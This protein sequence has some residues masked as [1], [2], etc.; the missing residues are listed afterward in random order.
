M[1][2]LVPFPVVLPLL[3]GTTLVAFSPISE[4]RITDA[5]S[6]ATALA[7]MVVC[8][9]L[10]HLSAGNTIVYWFGDWLPR[11]RVAMGISFVIDPMGA[12]LAAFCAFLMTVAFIY[13]IHYFEEVRTYFHALMLWF[14]AA[15]TGFCLTGDLFN[16]FVFFE[17]MSVTAFT[18][19]AYKVEE[20]QTPTGAFNFAVT[21]SIGGFLTLTGIALVYG[22]TGALNMAQAGVSLVNHPADA[23][24]MVAL[25]MIFSGFFIKAAIVPFHFWLGDAH[26]VA[27]APV[28]VLFSGVM[29]ELGLYGAFRVYWIV[30]HPSLLVIEPRIRVLLMTL[31]CST[32]VMGAIMCFLQRHLKRLLAFSS[33]SHV[34][35]MLMGAACLTAK[36]VAG[37]ALY[38]LAHGMVKGALFMGGGVLLARLGSVDEVMLARRGG[39][40]YLLASVF[41]FG[42]LG[43]AGFP[44][45]GPYLGKQIMDEAAKALGAKWYLYAFLFAS[46]VTGGAVLRFAG[47]VFFGFGRPA[48][49][50]KSPTDAERRETKKDSKAPILLSTATGLLVLVPLLMDAI[51]S[52]VVSQLQAAAE[53][54]VDQTAYAN[55]VLTGRA[56][57]PIQP[58]ESMWHTAGLLEGLCA[59]I[60]AAGLALVSCRLPRSVARR[61]HPVTAPVQSVLQ[62]L[63]SGHIGDLIVWLM[64]GVGAIGM[65]LAM[66]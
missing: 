29:I 52:R 21:N 55:A 30:F 46:I 28:C 59:A 3:I 53:R 6:V 32:A 17:L 37:A 13:T 39:K 26:A 33:I 43:L 40:F 35:M 2:W 45:F 62:K 12:G 1:N 22:R 47:V 50:S 48:E 42:G 19:A 25:A 8:G 60:G 20:D 11:H 44:P 31:G 51:G 57:G 64:I 56:T 41:V 15:M 24:V 58:V 34:G 66:D 27:P 36:G 18:L 5:L 16:L 4:R 9:W 49:E 10:T 63:H 14:L 61:I 38:L 54:F 23:L 7:V 65:I